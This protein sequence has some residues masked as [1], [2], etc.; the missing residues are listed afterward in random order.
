MNNTRPSLHVPSIIQFA[1]SG[2][3]LLAFWGAALIYI[4]AAAIQIFQDSTATDFSL[5]LLLAVDFAV[6]GFLVL[7]SLISS[8][9]RLIRRPLH[10]RTGAAPRIVLFVILF[11][12]LLLLLG[13]EMIKKGGW[14]M[15]FFPIVQVS[16]V[17]LVV[18]W[19]YTIAGRGLEK[20][21]RQ[22]RWGLLTSGM[23]GGT[24]LSIVAEL[25]LGLLLLIGFVALVI[26]IPGLQDEVNRL[27]SRI[28][29]A[30][31]D[32]D[33]LMRILTP[34]FTRP[35]V[36]TVILFSFSVAV[37]LVEEAL[38]PIGMWF[39]AK[40]GLTPAQ[41]FM[42]GV[43]SGAGFGL[44]ESL[45]NTASLMGDTWLTVTAMRFGTTLMHMLASGMVGWGLASAWT[46]RKF[47]RLA[48]AYLAAVFLH[49]LW[50]GLAIFLSI[51]LLMPG[52]TPEIIASLGKATLWGLGV[53]S[54]AALAILLVINA[55]L[56]K[57]L[58][59]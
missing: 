42:A 9:M 48:G 53:L 6:L 58:P 14:V 46:Q 17:L 32:I 5:S 26:M 43:I 24:F 44:M 49:G 54:V 23:L 52:Q 36:I 40:R 21:S 50:N 28:S 30:G 22:R 10:E 8:F 33:A 34:Y 27:A 55:R 1:V 16:S 25:L 56:R 2:F 13:S 51:S 38:K 41:G 7:P 19:L 37:P 20:G 29:T 11:W 31:S 57:T 35:A 47:I 59:A 18:F 39:L 15:G 45:F 12:P 3:G 4:L